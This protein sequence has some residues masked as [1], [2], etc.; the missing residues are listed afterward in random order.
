M[1]QGKSSTKL[2]GNVTEEMSMIWCRI[3]FWNG[4]IGDTNYTDNWQL[5]EI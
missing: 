4:T 3:S 1:P 2:Q 5:E